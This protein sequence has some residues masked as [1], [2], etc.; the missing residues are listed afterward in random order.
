MY[1][2]CQCDDYDFVQG[3]RMQ[4]ESKLPASWLSST[5][6]HTTSTEALWALRD[7]MMH[8]SLGVVRLM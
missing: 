4:D 8:E 1:L 7:F 3:I 6:E 5:G 2:I